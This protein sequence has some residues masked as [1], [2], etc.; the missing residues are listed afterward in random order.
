MLAVWTDPVWLED[1][2]AWIDGELARLGAVASAAI[3]QSH[4]RPWSTVMRVPVEG[5]SVWF[6]ANMPSQA[7]E[8]GVV[9]ILGRQRPRCVPELWAVDLERGWMLMEN[10]GVL[11][12]DV[13]A[14]ER[15]LSRWLNLLPLYAQL[16]INATGDTET[17]LRAGVPDRRLGSLASQYTRLLDEVR[18]LTPEEVVRLRRLQ[19]AVSEMCDELAAFGIPETIQHNDLHDGQVFVRDGRYLISDWAE[20]CLSHPFFTMAVTLEGNIAWGLDD[21]RDIVNVAPF[22]DAYLEPFSVYEQAPRLRSAFT[23]ALRLGWIC[24]AIDVQRWA[25][26]LAPPDREKQLDG[27]ATR[28]RMFLSGLR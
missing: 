4:V 21:V 14:R 13:V 24:R 5:A 3:E 25:S 18:G 20:S 15:S 6:K 12:G 16:Q 9:A 19:S 2:K 28:L 11:F 23:T 26:G 7:Y 17:F 22:R 8:A 27:V 1:V 10:A